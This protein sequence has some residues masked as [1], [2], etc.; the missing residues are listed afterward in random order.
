RQCRILMAVI[1]RS[2]WIELKIS[3][4]REQATK[5]DFRV[6][7]LPPWSELVHLR[8][9]VESPLRVL[10]RRKLPFEENEI[11]ELVCWF[12]AKDRVRTCWGT[13]GLLVK[14]IESFMTVHPTSGGLRKTLPALIESLRSNSSDRDNRKYAERLE[15]LL[16]TA[17]ELP[18]QPGEAWSDAALAV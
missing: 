4:K 16:G 17:P 10:L 2:D 8:Q 14:A 15:A 9:L 6:S 3:E 11:T 7:F 1:A 13:Q 12:T 5:S 18:L